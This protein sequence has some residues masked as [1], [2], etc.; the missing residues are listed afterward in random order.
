MDENDNGLWRKDLTRA[1]DSG[2]SHTAITYNLPLVAS[3][4]ALI[5]VYQQGC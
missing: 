5:A 2:I 4:L 1:V 3:L